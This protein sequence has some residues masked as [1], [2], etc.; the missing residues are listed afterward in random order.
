M[1][2]IDFR[3]AGKTYQYQLPASWDEVTKEQFI[4]LVAG[5]GKPTE[6]LPPDVVRDIIG[7]DDVVDASLEISDWWWL[8][9]RLGWM[10]EL[11]KI[12]KLIIQDVTLENGMVCYGYNDDMSDIAWEEFIFAD[13][14]ASAKRW[15]VVAAVLYRPERENWN[16][17]TDRR[18]PFSKYGA[19]K[20]SGAM[21]ALGKE[22]LDAIGVNY[23]LLR[24]QLTRKYPR[25][26]AEI[27]EDELVK[28][29]K[30]KGGGENWLSLIRN[31]MGDNFFEEEKYMSLPVPSVFFQINRVVKEN[32]E[33]MRHGGK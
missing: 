2:G 8:S 31:M 17:E 1:D 11:D 10:L 29:T 24:R 20:R 19:D 12:T 14:Y 18:I 23:L 32:N 30:K 21:A 3:V 5:L 7:I 28:K 33:R 6:G 25:I 26:F 22:T 16:G 13:T 9:N 15:D 27:E 4:R